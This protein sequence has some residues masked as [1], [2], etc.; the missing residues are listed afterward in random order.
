MIAQNVGAAIHVIDFIEASGQPL[1]YYVNE[2]RSK[3]YGNALCVLPHD[4]VSR[5]TV[6]G[7]RFEDH[8]KDA[9]FRTEIIVNQGLGAAKMRI[10]AA[11]RILP[12]CG[13]MRKTARLG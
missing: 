9:N 13:F 2:L 6:T 12:R 10:E 7:H 1:S 3:G 11:R 8:L 5:N 4:G